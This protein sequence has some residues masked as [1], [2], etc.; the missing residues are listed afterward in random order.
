MRSPHPSLDLPAFRVALLHLLLPHTSL[1]VFVMKHLHLLFIAPGID[2]AQPSA[3]PSDGEHLSRDRRET[4]GG[5]RHFQGAGPAHPGA[6]YRRRSGGDG[7]GGGRHGQDRCGGRNEC[8]RCLSLFFCLLLLM[9]VV[10]IKFAL[11]PCR[12]SFV[13]DRFTRASIT[14]QACSGCFIIQMLV[15]TS[16]KS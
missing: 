15:C 5:E 8:S 2:L 1:C 10:M 13:Y 4:K 16:N 3:N 14:V 12:R 6:G 9:V 7:E 11:L